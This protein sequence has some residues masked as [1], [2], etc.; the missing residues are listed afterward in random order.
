MF[1][2]SK[3]FRGKKGQDFAVQSKNRSIHVTKF[4]GENKWTAILKD[5]EGRDIFNLD[6][7][8]TKKKA[9]RYAEKIIKNY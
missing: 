9:M 6:T 7:F 1:K 2:T 8:K 4:Q 5:K 3:I